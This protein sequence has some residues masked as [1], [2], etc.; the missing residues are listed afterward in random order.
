LAGDISRQTVGVS[1]S[2]I[3][4]ER[5]LDELMAMKPK[6][7][8]STWLFMAVSVFSL[9]VAILALVVAYLAWQRPVTSPAGPTHA[10][11]EIPQ[12]SPTA[13]LLPLK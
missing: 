7:H 3:K 2:T 11:Q 8:W 4:V 10:I 5:K 13:T 6:V 9:A 12:Q 1:H